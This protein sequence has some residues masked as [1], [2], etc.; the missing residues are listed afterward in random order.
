MEGNIIRIIID[1][2][3]SM[4]IRSIQK[5]KVFRE[6]RSG[7]YGM[8]LTALLIYIHSTLV[9]KTLEKELI[10]HQIELIL[11]KKLLQGLK[12]TKEI[13]A[14]KLRMIWITIQT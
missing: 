11:Q 7:N 9:I 4:K 10:N 12:F 6:K 13:H 8:V 5:M 2:N 1:I 3:S 14:I